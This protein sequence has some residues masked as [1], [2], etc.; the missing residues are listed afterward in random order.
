VAIDP[1]EVRTREFLA[2]RGEPLLRAAV[3]LTGSRPAGEDL[4]QAALER[5]LRHWRDIAG[6]PAGFTLVTPP[7]PNP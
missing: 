4:L 3:L 7:A 6:D 1:A 2:D 5:M